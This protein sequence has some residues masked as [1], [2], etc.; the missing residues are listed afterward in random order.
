MNRSTSE[1]RNPHSTTYTWLNFFSYISLSIQS[2]RGLCENGPNYLT[3]LWSTR[4]KTSRI[5]SPNTSTHTRLNN[6]KGQRSCIN[7]G[8]FIASTNIVLT[9]LEHRKWLEK[10]SKKRRM[11][12]IYSTNC[13]SNRTPIRLYRFAFG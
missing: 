10:K 12:D 6:L 1:K 4:V 2:H 11:S 7:Y 13:T 9:Y 5:S 3:Q 8:H